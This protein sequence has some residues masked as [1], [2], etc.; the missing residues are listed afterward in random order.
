M[1][2]KRRTHERRITI[3]SVRKNPPD[4]TKLGQ[5]LIALAEAQAEAEAEAEAKKPTEVASTPEDSE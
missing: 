4:F 1:T 5:A 2:N 3:R